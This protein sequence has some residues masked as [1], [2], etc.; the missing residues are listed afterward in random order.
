MGFGYV[1]SEG[2]GKARRALARAYVIPADGQ[3]LLLLT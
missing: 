2:D 1:L 3:R